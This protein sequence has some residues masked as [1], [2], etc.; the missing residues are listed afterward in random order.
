MGG[1]TTIV[2]NDWHDRPPKDVKILSMVAEEYVHEVIRP[3]RR[4]RMD[5]KDCSGLLSMLDKLI[6]NSEPE[7]AEYL[8]GYQRGMR[9]SIIGVSEEWIGEH[10]M[11]MDPDGGTGDPFIDSFARGYRHGFEG[12]TPESPSFSESPTSLRIAYIV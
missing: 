5:E 9:V 10:G 7:R 12:N 1:S 8:R 11:F 6:D 2:M 3:V 4:I